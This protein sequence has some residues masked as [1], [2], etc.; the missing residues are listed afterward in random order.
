MKTNA[1]LSP[2]LLVLSI[3]HTVADNFGTD[4]YTSTCSPHLFELLVFISHRLWLLTYTAN[5][6]V[7]FPYFHRN[8]EAFVLAWW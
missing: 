7:Y 5:W 4:M 8:W 1:A 3:G 2:L 6:I